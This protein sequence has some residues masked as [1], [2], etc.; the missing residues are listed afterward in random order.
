[1][2]HRGFRIG[3]HFSTP[4][5]LQ[6]YLNRAYPEAKRW[7]ALIALADK[8]E[9]EAFQ[10]LCDALRD[11][12][13]MMRRTALEAVKRHPRAEEARP[14]IV[15]LLFDLNDDVRQ[16]ACRVCAELGWQE[17][18]GGVVTLLEEDNPDVRD[19]AVSALNRLWQDGDFDLVLRLYRGDTRRA[20]RIAAAKTLRKHVGPRNWRR[21]FTLW[22]HD[23]EV[24]HRLWACELVVRFGGH[25][26]LPRVTPL[27]ND[28][29]ENV[30]TAARDA[31]DKLAA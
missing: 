13:W 22:A 3:P 27:L 4:L 8:P 6:L 14:E 9:P 7:A 18:R 20:V 28:R 12:H 1:M 5:L 17:A 23:R 31:V 21:L 30:R 24:R 2:L 16:V 25:A 19:V 29:N 26:Y 15:R 10:V 11:E